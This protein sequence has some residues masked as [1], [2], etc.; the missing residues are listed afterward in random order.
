[1]FPRDA[2]LLGGLLFALLF[3]Y[4]YCRYT[5]VQGCDA[6]F[7]MKFWKKSLLIITSGFI[8][9]LILVGAL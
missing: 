7:T 9:G 8:L 2:Y 5:Y 4:P 3:W 6:I 1:M